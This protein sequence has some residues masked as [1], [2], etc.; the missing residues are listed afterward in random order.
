MLIFRAQLCAE[1]PP[2]CIQSTIVTENLKRTGHITFQNAKDSKVPS[3]AM[4]TLQKLQTAAADSLLALH[5]LRDPGVMSILTVHMIYREY[6]TKLPSII[7]LALNSA[8]EV[9]ALA[10]VESQAKTEFAQYSMWTNTR[11]VKVEPSRKYLK[12]IAAQ[13]NWPDVWKT[14]GTYVKNKFTDHSDSILT[15]LKNYGQVSSRVQSQLYG[16]EIDDVTR[17]LDDMLFDWGQEEMNYLNKMT[18]ALGPIE[19]VNLLNEYP[20]LRSD[21]VRKFMS[22]GRKAFSRID[23]VRNVG[24][25]HLHKI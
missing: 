25:W 14:I 5:E 16:E 3:L 7:C 15:T 2:D 23:K 11:F 19:N 21:Y 12:L 6:L 8:D 9:S 20:R 18:A 13:P 17:D 10:N 22:F 4:D 1:F 24:Q